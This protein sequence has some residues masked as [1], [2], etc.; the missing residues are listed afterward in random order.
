MVS[1]SVFDQ[2]LILFILIH[3]TDNKCSYTLERKI[4]FLYRNVFIEISNLQLAGHNAVV[5]ETAADGVT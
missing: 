2:C 3:K 1:V 5:S 4:L